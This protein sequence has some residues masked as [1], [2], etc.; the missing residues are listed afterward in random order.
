MAETRGVKE[1]AKSLLQLLEASSESMN[2]I[3]VISSVI[4]TLPSEHQR[5]SK[6]QKISNFSAD[7]ADHYN[8]NKYGDKFMWECPENLRDRFSQN[9]QSLRRKL[10]PLEGVNRRVRV[11]NSPAENMSQSVFSRSSGQFAAPS[12]PS[13]RDNFRLRKPNTSRPP[14]MHVDDY[15]ARE[16][17]V[18]GT[19]SN[20]IAVP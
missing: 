17:N 19:T 14:S 10:T 13:R 15:V 18:D 1:Y 4:Q 6:I 12:V 20:V 8:L 3:E 7:R 16:R 2:P 11:D 5:P 9:G